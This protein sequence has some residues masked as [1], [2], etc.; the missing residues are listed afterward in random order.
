LLA[1][2]REDLED[3]LVG[4][5]AVRVGVGRL[6]FAADGVGAKDIVGSL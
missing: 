1:N 5:A 2:D 4:A 3:V 6:G